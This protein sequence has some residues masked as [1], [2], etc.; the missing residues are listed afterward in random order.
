MN[1]A[2]ALK[3]A[4]EYE[5]TPGFLVHFER[6][7]GGILATDYTPDPRAGDK[8][9]DTAEEAWAFAERLSS[10]TRG[11]FVN[12]YVVNARTFVPVFDYAKRMIANR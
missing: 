4:D 1:Y 6:V 12:F 9:F 3:I 2:S 7:E 10:A 11:R 8:P 5:N